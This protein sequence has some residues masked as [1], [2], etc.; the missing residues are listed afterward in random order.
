MMDIIGAAALI[1]GGASGLGRATAKAL[2]E[3]GAKVALLDID[4][5]AA[6]TAAK[7]LGGLGLSCDVTKADVV[8]GAVAAARA[9]H[10]SARIVVNCAG[11]GRAGR[12][13]ERD[14]K[15]MPLDQFR[16]VVEVNLIGSFNLL[17]V[18]AA[19]MIG[20]DPLAEGERGAILLTA[21]IAA[22]DGQIGQA[23]YS[24]SKGG[25]AGLTLPAA[26]ELAR[27]GVRVVAIAPGV[28]ATPM[29]ARLPEA[30]Q[31]SL[32]ANVPFPQRL[33]R[34]D[35]YAALALHICRNTM[36]NGEVIRLD[37]ALRMPPR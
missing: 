14:G 26:R 16:Q 28:F 9:A 25:I 29:L 20:L 7:E 32:A 35:E 21:S 27:Y 22:F 13:V 17:R 6:E 37:G 2:A 19:D 33:G 18:A 23:A 3:A 8:E 34:P 15:P 10:G 5:A 4:G 12:I 30:A 24:A 36:L 1:S 11:I 31:T